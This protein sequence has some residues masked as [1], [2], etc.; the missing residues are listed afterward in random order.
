MRFCTVNVNDR[1]KVKLT[2]TG[3]QIHRAGHEKL[4]KELPIKIRYPYIPPKEDEEGYAVFQM[5]WLMNLFGPYMS[6]CEEP[7]FETTIKVEVKDEQD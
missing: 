2:E 4:M 3:K 6:V 5:W 7:P 1:V